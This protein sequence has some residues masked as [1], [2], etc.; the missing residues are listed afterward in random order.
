MTLR[1][2]SPQ[3]LQIPP[4]ASSAAP[5]TDRLIAVPVPGGIPRRVPRPARHDGQVFA[6]GDWVAARLTWTGTNT[7]GS[8]QR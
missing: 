2:H 3:G 4:S 7:G 8:E 6:F 1:T 5:G